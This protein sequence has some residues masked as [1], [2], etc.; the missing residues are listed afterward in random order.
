MRDRAVEAGNDAMVEGS[1]SIAALR[2][3]LAR[4]ARLEGVQIR[5]ATGHTVVDVGSVVV[6]LTLD[7]GALLRGDVALDRVAVAGVFVDLHSLP[8]GRLD[9]AALFGVAPAD[10]DAPAEP[11]GG[12][13]VD[14][15]IAALDLD[16][17]TL[18][19]TDADGVTTLDVAI[20]R[21]TG[22]LRI[23][24]R[25]VHVDDLTATL[26]LH[27]PVDLPVSAAGSLGLVAGA[28]V[29]DDLRL[30]SGTTTL[31]IDGSVARAETDP[32]LGLQ[33]RAVP[34][35]AAEVERLAGAPVLRRDVTLDLRL[36]GAL[37]A[38]SI[39]GRL[40]AGAL[41]ALDLSST[42]GLT[43]T[44][45]TWRVRAETDGLDLHDLLVDV[46]EPV[47]LDLVASAEG[48]GTAWPGEL[49]ARFSVAG[50]QQ[51]LW[52]ERISGLE[53]DGAV[54]GGVVTLE[55]AVARHGVGR[56]AASGRVDVPASRA[57]VTVD[58][59]IPALDALQAF[60]APSLEGGGRFV[61]PV[62]A[63]WSGD[64]IAVDAAGALSAQGVGTE[65]LSVAT[66]RGP[67]AVKVRG[68]LVAGTGELAV[69]GLVGPGV[70]LDIATAEISGTYHPD[71]GAAGEALLT[72]DGVAVGDGA[73]TVS[74]IHGTVAGKS[75]SG[76]RPVASADLVVSDLL[77]GPAEV[78]AEGGP[79]R[80]RIDGDAL[81]IGFQLARKERPFFQGEVSARLDTAE[82]R[83]DGLAVAPLSDE[84]F[85]ADEPVSFRLADGGIRDLDARLVGPA[86]RLEAHGTWLP[87]DRGASNL[88][89]AVAD[90][91]LS[92]VAGITELYLPRGEAPSLAGLE[93]RADLVAV[94]RGAGG[95]RLSADATV[96]D[97][98]VPASLGVEIAGLDVILEVDGPLDRLALT[99][100]LRDDRMLLLDLSGSVP[101]AWA[102]GAPGVAC[103]EPVE[104]SALLAPGRLQRWH[105]R[106]PTVP[107]VEGFG[108]ASITL[109]GA[110]CDPDVALVSTWSLPVGTSGEYARLDLDVAREGDVL[111]VW[112]AGEERLARRFVVAGEAGTRA[113][114]ALARLLAGDPDFDP[115]RPDAWIGDLDLRL[116]PMAVPLDRLAALGGVDAHLQGTLLGGVSLTGP[117]LRPQAAG[118]LMV[119]GGKVGSIPLDEA[120]L[121]LWPD[122]DAGYQLDARLGFG[123][124]A[125]LG[126]VQVGGLVP[127]V[128]DLNADP[129]DLLARDGLALTVSGDGVPLA[130]AEGLV[131]DITEA[132]GRLTVAGTVGGSLSAPVPDLT[133]SIVDGVVGHRDLG[134]RYADLDL[135]LVAQGDTVTLTHLGVETTRE[136]ALGTPSVRGNQVG[137]LDAKGRMGLT[138]DGIGAIRLDLEGDG[139]WLASMSN[140]AMRVDGNIA[141]RGDWPRLSVAGGVEML[142][143]RIVLD[144]SVFV[145]QTDLE[146]DSGITVRR[147]DEA[148]ARKRKDESS[149]FETLD[150]DLHLDLQRGLRLLAAVPLQDEMGKEVAAL[151]T[152]YLS[153]DLASPDLAVRT[154][155]GDLVVNGTLELP[156][157]EITVVGSKFELDVTQDN[158]LAFISDDYTEPSVAITA[159]KVTGSYGTVSTRVE[160]TPSDLSVSFENPDY[161]DETDIMSI[162]LFGKPA[163]E[164]SDSEGQAGGDMLA[165]AV[166]MMARSSL[167][168]AL[169]GTFKADLSFDEDSFKVGTPLGDRLFASLELIRDTEE[170]TSGYQV[171][172]E[173]LITRRMYAELAGGDV[174]NSADLFWRWRF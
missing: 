97:L 116:V 16:D 145:G 150:L 33:V 172:L 85:V 81:E 118:A 55:R 50:R 160:G 120:Q 143:G 47:H 154:K 5:D 30:T 66:V 141:V 73:L 95:G 153:A 56:V 163:S 110:L 159:N 90:L 19:L 71:G 77:L 121:T 8:D 173:W 53:V 132:A 70:S 17:L 166:G 22:G 84:S 108:S 10:P 36:H 26:D 34:L 102:D 128:L 140:L 100:S 86:G 131:T 137:R 13:G 93:G 130:I 151:S 104:L 78:E 109:T 57:D 114:D 41:G 29:L 46:P 82:W 1:L 25:D 96:S 23:D 37:A 139:F 3:D 152:V 68:D 149:I 113:S 38:L 169:G 98:V 21:A 12:V 103:A 15:A 39:D 171:T 65:G 64:A 9:V 126:S 119:A 6:D 79:V 69:T 45:L 87:T 32:A 142:E 51:V 89:V 44:P 54:A 74:R 28:A 106:I 136:T 164:L 158:A 18:R 75:V 117:V 134:V 123:R 35:G 72:A 138:P 170:A 135:D 144:E 24:G 83:I 127:V 40:G 148:H 167:N 124:D 42:L 76:G 88:R 49:E 7:P 125:A 112:S 60:G 161:P 129:E 99:G 14:L 101:L 105:S 146:L 147:N 63:D 31:A 2:T 92:R 59:T 20:P 115:A 133:V 91:D 80:A 58:A 107:E 48:V 27:A 155:D 165:A 43:A 94:F 52:G 162:L 11:F 174:G 122:G 61:G 4:R 157:G 67:V 168:Q 111:R 156:Q 62:V